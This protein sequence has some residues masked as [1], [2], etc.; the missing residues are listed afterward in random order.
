LQLGLPG[1]T[2][3]VFDNFIPLANVLV[4]KGLLLNVEIEAPDIKEAIKEAQG[5]T[6]YALS[7][8]SC[9]SL[10]AVEP[11]KP[12][13]AYNSTANV[14]E[15]DYRIYLYDHYVPVG[16]RVLERSLVVELLG[17]YWDVF[18]QNPEIK[19]DFKYR[20]QRAIWSFRRGL[21]D[22]GD[23]LSEF[24]THWT[25][26]EG[27][28]CVFRKVF[29][30]RQSS[31]MDGVRKVFVE[32][33]APVVFE[34]LKNLRHEL[35][36]GNFGVKDANDIAE[37]HIELVRRAHIMMI[38]SILKMPESS[39]QKIVSY[40]S[41]KKAFTPTVILFGTV[42]CE[43]GSVGSLEGHPSVAIELASLNSSPQRGK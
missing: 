5:A 22:D 20:V 28:D 6:S 16:K 15:R 11:P 1:V 23:V 36:H 42:D 14:K 29:P 43:P 25:S 2:I 18:S 26:M 17:H 4:P 39:R 7:V 34:D 13:W 19:E 10:A 32:L 9:T 31:T 30:S 33:K 37:E 35:A 27:L 40:T 41:L 12:L 3:A 8:V 24:L 21:S 38:M